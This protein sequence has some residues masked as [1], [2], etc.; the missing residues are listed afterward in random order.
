MKTYSNPIV[1][2]ESYNIYTPI[3]SVS[4]NVLNGVKEG[5]EYPIR[6]R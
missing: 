4:S 6:A 3:L 5:E 2:I 1:T